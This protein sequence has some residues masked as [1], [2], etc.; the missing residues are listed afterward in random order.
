MVNIKDIR[1]SNAAIRSTFADPVALFVGGTSGI[2]RSALEQLVKQT[3]RPTVYLVGRSQKAGDE[4][5]QQA[6]Q[7]NPQGTY[8]FI[9]ADVSLVANVDKVCEQI[10][11]KE[12]KLDFM[13]LSCGYVDFTGIQREYLYLY[14]CLLQL[15]GNTVG[16]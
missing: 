3:V 15:H 12:K 14:P 9:S 4:I 6:K 2:G 11:A 8:H 16:I 13:V 7:T 10:K 5:V 1:A